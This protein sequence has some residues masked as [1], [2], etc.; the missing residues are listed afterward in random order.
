MPVTSLGSR[1]G[2]NWM[3]RTLHAIERADRLGQQGLA[4]AGDVLDED[5][6]LGQQRDEREADH[7]GLA[8]DDRRDVDRDALEGS[9]D[10]LDLRSDPSLHGLP[11]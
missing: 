1:S 6:A 9:C 3:R 10:A 2:V 4:D 7:L 5:V 11:L 8:L